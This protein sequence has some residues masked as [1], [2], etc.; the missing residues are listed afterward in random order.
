MMTKPRRIAGTNAA[1][2]G[3]TRDD[4]DALHRR[5]ESPGGAANAA[6]E[7][8]HRQAQ[9]RLGGLRALR[10]GRG[11]PVERGVVG[12]R[13]R[14]AD[15]RPASPAACWWRPSRT[16]LEPRDRAGLARRRCRE[17]APRSC[18]TSRPSTVEDDVVGAQARRARP[19][20]RPSR[21]APA[22][23]ASTASFSERCSVRRHVGQR[24][25]HEAARHAAARLQ[26]RQ[27]RRP[28]G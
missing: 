9:R 2:A 4:H 7:L 16:T 6:I 1:P 17:S 3:S 28:P 26:L 12:G 11:G 19:A 27:D 23:R 22:R 24:D 14:A 15:A 5:R 8:A 25:A 20:S 18:Q 10:A 13:R 21:P